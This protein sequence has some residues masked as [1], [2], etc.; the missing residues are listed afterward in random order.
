M[1]NAI[2]SLTENTIEEQEMV[3]LWYEFNVLPTNIV[4]L[5][6]DCFCRF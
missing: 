1:E 3:M 4:D 2:I 6:F 5:I